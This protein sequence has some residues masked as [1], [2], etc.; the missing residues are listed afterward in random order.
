MSTNSNNEQPVSKRQRIDRLTM[1]PQQNHNAG[2]ADVL[3]NPNKNIPPD[4]GP[5]EQITTKQLNEQNAISINGEHTAGQNGSAPVEDARADEPSNGCSDQL[6]YPRIHNTD[7][8]QS[9]DELDNVAVNAASL[10]HCLVAGQSASTPFSDCSTIKSNSVSDVEQFE[11]FLANQCLCG[12][13]NRTLRKTFESHWY[14]DADGQRQVAMLSE[15]PAYNLIQFLSNIQL[16]TNL[17]L[18]QNTKGQICSKIM[19]V[20][21]HIQRDDDMIEEIFK[22]SK[23]ENRFV[24]FLAG[25][26]V[27]NCFV[28]A[29]DNQDIYE[30]WLTTLV[31]NLN[32]VC[33][34]PDHPSIDFAG[35]RRIHFSLDIILRILEWKDDDQAL[36]EPVDLEDEESNHE[37]S[38]YAA[39]HSDN[40]TLPLVV[41]PIENNFFA[42]YYS[43]ENQSTSSQGDS[44]ETTAER[45]AATSVVPNRD[46]RTPPSINHTPASGSVPPNAEPT[47]Q[48]HYLSD[49]ESFDTTD[50]KSN[51]VAHLKKDW[52]RLVDRMNSVIHRLHARNEVESAES[53]IITYLTLW[54]RIISVQA[55]LSVDSTLPFH[56]ELPLVVKKVLIEIPLPTAI[57]KQL[58]T[59]LNE[60]L[61]Y[62]TTLALQSTLPSETNTLAHDIFNKV[63]SQQIFETMPRPPPPSPSESITYPLA[64][65]MMDDGTGDEPA[66]PPID[67]DSVSTANPEPK[68]TLRTLIQ[69]LVLLILKS[70]AVT[71]KVLRNE[72]SSDSSMDG[73]SSTSSNDY[74]AFQEALQIE[75]ATRDVL[76]RLKRFM[77]TNLDHHPETHFSKMLIYLFSDQDEYL[78]ESMLC[79]LDITTVFLARQPTYGQ[80]SNPSTSAR[81]HFNTLLAMLSPVYTFLEFLRLIEYKVEFLLDLLVSN[82]T[83]FLLYLLRFLKYIRKDWSTFCERCNGWLAA[84]GGPNPMEGDIPV[85][86]RT[87]NVLTQLRKLI[88]RLV[89]QSLFP[90]DISPIV[91]LLRQ[92]ES[93]FEGNEL[94]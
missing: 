55:N 83:C 81:H 24:Q 44:Q 87:M 31:S 21:D 11:I 18:R 90:Y 66:P 26:V 7:G 42:A 36:E 6:N 88:E 33:L 51:I 67:D 49:S 62:G 71:V 69:K 15:W 84:S 65:R 61:C 59:L 19:D 43:N 64:R 17:Y 10:E 74:E 56:E 73:Y 40:F 89:F 25:R 77:R 47:C 58:L 82:E 22:L 30:D 60:S 34:P 9:A 32:G 76:K 13:S 23:Y 12:I 63:K 92:C 28:I 80:A 94:F 72:D 27:A 5:Q 91:L 57:Y 3:I 79:T 16:L 50:L 37:Q 2:L 68:R 46:H 78:I 53:I 20:F 39:I 48:Y 41:P 45:P 52:S 38:A 86:D 85:L 70:V 35:L 75:R 29:K 54:E 4:I 14:D 93:L 1:A 8:N